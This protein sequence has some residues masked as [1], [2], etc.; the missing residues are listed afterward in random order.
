MSASGRLVGLGDVLTCKL[1]ACSLK[2]ECCALRAR[3]L[4]L[5]LVWPPTRRRQKGPVR[6]CRP[7]EA[8]SALPLDD[9]AGLSYISTS[10]N[11]PSR[12]FQIPSFREGCA[13]FASGA[14]SLRSAISLRAA[15]CHRSVLSVMEILM[16]F[17]RAA[18]NRDARSHRKLN[19]PK[20]AIA[21]A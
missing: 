5:P 12:A 11:K 6:G 15:Q 19:F 17:S 18:V 16:I 8:P 3:R 10:S 4:F 14:S 7:S 9:P 20:A 21:P 1:V 2:G 13:A